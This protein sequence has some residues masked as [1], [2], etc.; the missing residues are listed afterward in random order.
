M[1][2]QLSNYEKTIKDQDAQLSKLKNENVR[3]PR[4]V[5]LAAGSLLAPCH[6]VAFRLSSGLAHRDI[7]HRTDGKDKGN[8]RNDW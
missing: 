4:G 6:Y 8:A 5:V 3:C 1:K 2:Q 7:F